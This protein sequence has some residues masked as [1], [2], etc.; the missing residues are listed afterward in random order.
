MDSKAGRIRLP[1]DES[2]VSKEMSDQSRLHF[3]RMRRIFDR[4]KMAFFAEMRKCA[5]LR[6]PGKGANINIK[7]NFESDVLA[8]ITYCI[9][10]HLFKTCVAKIH[11]KED[12][13][14]KKKKP[15]L[16]RLLRTVLG[17]TPIL[18]VSKEDFWRPKTF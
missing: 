14:K 11:G 18:F 13:D 2:E 8:A 9:M 3:Y 5:E 10:C 17:H 4:D 6:K 7:G 1:A 15:C 12:A 16:T